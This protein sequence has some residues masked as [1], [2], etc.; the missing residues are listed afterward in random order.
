[1]NRIGSIVEKIGR[2]TA[3][4]LAG[5]AAV[6]LAA[7]A[8]AAAAAAGGGAGAPP[9][10]Q[11]PVSSTVSP[12]PAAPPTATGPSRPGGHGMNDDSMGHGMGM[13]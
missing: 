10:E 4:M 9:P 12:L 3:L 11:A 6:V 7:V 8:L 5:G 13:R 1:M 2:R